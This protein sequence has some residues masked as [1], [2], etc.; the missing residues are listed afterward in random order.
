MKKRKMMKL[1]M[2]ALTMLLAFCNLLSEKEGL[3]P[4]Y[5]VKGSTNAGKWGEGGRGEEPGTVRMSTA[6][7]IRVESPSCVSR[8]R[9]ARAAYSSLSAW[10]LGACT[11][12]PRLRF[13]RRN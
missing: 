12:G 2:F 13:S 8:V 10:L 4:C 9:R 7:S 11:A 5:S 3:K 6:V 1:G